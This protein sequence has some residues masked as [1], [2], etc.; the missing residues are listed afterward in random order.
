MILPRDPLS[1]RQ[2]VKVPSLFDKVLKQ[3]TVCICIYIIYINSY[4]IYYMYTL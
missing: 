1:R 3:Y 2:E 4:M